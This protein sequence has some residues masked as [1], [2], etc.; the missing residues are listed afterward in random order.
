MKPEELRYDAEKALRYSDPPKI[1]VF[2][3]PNLAVLDRYAELM[4]LRYRVIGLHRQI[5]KAGIFQ[6]IP[7][8]TSETKNGRPGLFWRAVFRTNSGEVLG[9]LPRKH[10][11]GSKPEQLLVWKEWIVR[12]TLAM[13]LDVLIHEIGQTLKRAY[14]VIEG[15]AGRLERD[16][17][18]RTRRWE[19]LR[20]ES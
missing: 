12:T 10:Y 9:G 19:V 18:Q 16:L 15:E 11:I 1:V 4:R 2:E 5:V 20:D 17:E 14:R 8:L 13:D 7:T 3:K 6:S